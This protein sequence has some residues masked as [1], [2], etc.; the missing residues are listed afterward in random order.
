MALYK[1]NIIAGPYARL[2][3][4]HVFLQLFREGRVRGERPARGERQEMGD[5]DRHTQGALYFCHSP[6]PAKWGAPERKCTYP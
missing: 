5:T 3:C 6:Y 4:V 1:S 2:V